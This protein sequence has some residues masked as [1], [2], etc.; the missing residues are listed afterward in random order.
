MRLFRI[1]NHLPALQFLLVA[2]L[3]DTDPL[4]QSWCFLGCQAALSGQA[5]AG[6]PNATDGYYDEECGNSLHVSSVYLCTRKYCSPY[7]FQVGVQ[8]AKETCAMY[9]TV[10]LLSPELV[11]NVSDS[12]L[13]GIPTLAYG[14]YPD[15]IDTATIPNAELFDL[16][17]KTIVS[18]ASTYQ[19]FPG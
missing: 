17:F 19:N 11:S 16:G 13:D 7:E 14:D 2:V 9:S 15:E 5:Y 3:A 10:P 8:F 4:R 1:F 18:E 6:S 12:D